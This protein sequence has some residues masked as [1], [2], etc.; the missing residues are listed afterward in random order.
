MSRTLRYGLV[1]TAIIA[2][3]NLFFTSIA[4]AINSFLANS[5]S[6]KISIITIFSIIASAL[7]AYLIVS[8]SPIFR[9]YLSTFRRLLRLESLSHP[10]L[11]KF[12]HDAPGTYHHT[13][14]VANIASRA[15]K[16]IGS[17]SL[18]TRVGAY[19]HDIGKMISPDFFVENQPNDQ[20]SHD[21]ID[22][23]SQSAQIIID[24]VQKGVELAKENHLPQ[25]VIDF[26]QQ[27]HGTSTASYF[28]EKSKLENDKP[29]K[30]DFKYSGPKPQ[31]PEIAIVML[32]DTLE[33]TVRSKPNPTLQDI[34]EIV[35]QTI[36][37]RTKDGQLDAS[38][39]NSKQIARLRRSFIE[40]LNAIFHRRIQYP[41][42]SAKT[43]TKDDKENNIKS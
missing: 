15:A 9:E 34:K 22:D 5:I 35:N 19:Y 7:I 36:E 27:H 13:L 17:D 12:S 37:E 3:I 26:I 24:H 39:L 32:A 41:N 21:N 28:Y 4:Y 2:G 33:A 11:V 30:S 8:T 23:P 42:G 1:L 18:L 14:T 38:T 31:S 40:S 43:I 29:K 10:L 6:L 16:A 20:N 25:E